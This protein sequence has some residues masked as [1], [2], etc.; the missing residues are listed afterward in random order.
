MVKWWGTA[1]VDE[2]HQWLDVVE[3]LTRGLAIRGSEKVL[4][5]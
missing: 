3:Q 2:L 4:G 1:P 5:S